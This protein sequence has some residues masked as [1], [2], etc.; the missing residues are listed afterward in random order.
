MAGYQPVQLDDEDAA[1][2]ISAN[3]A[4]THGAAASYPPAYSSGSA[5]GAGLA[6]QQGVN[7][8]H[9][10]TKNIQGTFYLDSDITPELGRFRNEQERTEAKNAYFITSGKMDIVLYLRG[11]KKTSIKVECEMGEPAVLDIVCLRM[12]YLCKPS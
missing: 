5:S 4:T 3:A 7:Y 1:P 10:A 6:W 11:Q 8:I 12:I 2:D 9:R